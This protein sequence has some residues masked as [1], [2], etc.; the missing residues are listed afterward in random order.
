LTV[1]WHAFFCVI[2]LLARAGEAQTFFK[3]VTDEIGAVLVMNRSSAFGD[4]DN[5]GWPDI[6]IAEDRLS[7]EH[8]IR[9]LH[10]EGDDRFEERAA[11]MQGD[12]AQGKM[13]GGGAIFGDYDNDGDLD[14]FV[15]VGSY[16]EFNG[17]TD[18]IEVADRDSLTPSHISIEFWIKPDSLGTGNQDI[19]AKRTGGNAGGYLIESISTNPIYHY[20]YIGGWK[21]VTF[22]Y[23]NDV[24]QHIAITYDGET[25]RGYTCAAYIKRY[26]SFLKRM[27]RSYGKR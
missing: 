14:L 24:W 19:I 9:L 12:L 20:L 17:S 18:Y 16:L 25:I 6:L 1:P 8:R 26:L 22:H 15:P 27:S 5:D 3:E 2:L 10:N 23:T 13:K 4:Y 7:V 21:W 11:S